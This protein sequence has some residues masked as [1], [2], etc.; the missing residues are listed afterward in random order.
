MFVC[1][2]CGARVRGDDETVAQSPLG[3][4]WHATPVPNYP[5]IERVCGPLRAANDG[6]DFCE[7]A[8]KGGW[9]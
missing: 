3:A 2:E 5:D 4:V 9:T 6:D 8:E 1:T 7:W